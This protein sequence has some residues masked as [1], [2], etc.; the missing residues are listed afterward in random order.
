MHELAESDSKSTKFYFAFPDRAYH[1]DC[2]KCDALCCKG[3]GIGTAV[4]ETAA[5][6][7]HYPE[8]AWAVT[9][10]ARKGSDF[11]NPSG[12][13]FFLTAENLCQVEQE[14][15]RAAKPGVC[16]L[17]PFNDFSR[18]GDVVVVRPHFLCPLRLLPGEGVGRH[19][20]IEKMLQETGVISRAIEQPGPDMPPEEARRVVKREEKFRDKC[21]AAIGRSSFN[22]LLELEVEDKKEFHE[23][24]KQALG[25]WGISSHTSSRDHLDV[26]PRDYLDD[27]LLA[28]APPLR[29]RLLHPA[30]RL[31]LRILFMAGV[32]LRKVAQITTRPLSLQGAHQ[33]IVNQLSVFRLFAR[34]NVSLRLPFPEASQGV[35]FQNPLMT[36]AFFQVLEEL[37]GGEKLFDV[38]DAAMPSGVSELEKAIFFHQLAQRIQQLKR[39]QRNKT[40]ENLRR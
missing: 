6:L 28:L 15:G 9:R 39:I 30:E 24:R 35:E 2:A 23:W 21:G 17:F 22:E 12:G 29:I 32:Y 36:V 14:H 33:M 37:Q 25:L 19:A 4:K 1:Y 27:I 13:C 20:D 10:N 31:R 34:G 16:V 26:I 40:F 18:I 38:L 5:L 11:I 8:L 7:S 3:H